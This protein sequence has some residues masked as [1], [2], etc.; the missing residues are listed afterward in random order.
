MR[1]ARQAVEY[2]ARAL[3]FS[4]LGVARAD[5]PQ[6]NALKYWINRGCHAGMDWLERHLP[7]RLNPQLVLPGARS[8]IILTYEYPRSDARQQK[9]IIARYAQGEDYHKLLSPKLA[10]LDETLSFYGGKQVCFSD[11]GPISER[12]FAAQAGLGWIGR[13]GLLVRLRGGS[14]CFL[15]SILTTLDLPVDSPIPNH[16]GKCRRCE[17]SCPTGALHEGSCD[18]RLCLSYWT[19]EARNEQDKLPPKVREAL[20][21]RMFG[22]DTCQEVC[23]WNRLPPAR[24]VDPHLLMPVRLARMPLEELEHLEG[25]PWQHFFAGSSV[26]RAGE[27][28]LHRTLQ[29]LHSSSEA[30]PSLELNKRDLR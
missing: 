14:F 29:R 22:C 19:I 17:E 9:G 20:G 10:D 28:L 16:C 27:K 18:A 3:G 8:V 23:P 5:A 4:A 24:K 13:N 7:A 21:E 26:R 2:A 12:F 25:E 1:E 15:S 11:S 30:T 6:G